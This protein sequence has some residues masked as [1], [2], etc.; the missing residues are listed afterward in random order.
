MAGKLLSLVFINRMAN[1][2]I[3]SFDGDFALA[4][5]EDGSGLLLELDVELG[6]SR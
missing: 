5:W 4:R 6:V 3:R 2:C 1:I